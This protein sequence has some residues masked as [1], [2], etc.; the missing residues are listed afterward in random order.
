MTSN[1]FEPALSW[2]HVAISITENS[3]VATSKEMLTGFMKAAAPAEDVSDGQAPMTAVLVPPH[4]AY[5][6][7]VIPNL[8]SYVPLE[9][10]CRANSTPSFMRVDDYPKSV[11]LNSC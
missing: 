9:L 5:P 8:L 3:A 2:C 6:M 10:F 7:S 1:S 11:L 4:R